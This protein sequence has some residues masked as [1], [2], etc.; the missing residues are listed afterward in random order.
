MGEIDTMSRILDNEHPLHAAV[1]MR[2]HHTLP[3]QKY[4]HCQDIAELQTLFLLVDPS[5]LYKHNSDHHVAYM[6]VSDAVNNLT[7]VLHQ[8][9]PRTHTSRST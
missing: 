9:N 7:N 1:Q 2:C 6:T 5:I 8:G 3:P 4:W